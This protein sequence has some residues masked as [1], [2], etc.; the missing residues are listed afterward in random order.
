[1]TPRLLTKSWGF[2]QHPPTGCHSIS[3]V[4]DV[5]GPYGYVGHDGPITLRNF[6]AR[7]IHVNQDTKPRHLG[8]SARTPVVGDKG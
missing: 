7:T 8:H 4:A 2:E 5:R 6:V 1:M 3:S